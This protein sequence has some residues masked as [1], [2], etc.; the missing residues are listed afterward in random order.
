MKG[1]DVDVAAGRI[2][3]INDTR[4]VTTTDGTLVCILPTVQS[5]TPTMTLPD[6]SKDICYLWTTS[7]YSAG[8]GPLQEGETCC[9]MITALPQEYS[10]DTTLMAVP[11]GADFF[12]GRVKISRTTAPATTWMGR[13]LGVLPVQSQW[14]SIPGSFSALVESEINLS[15]GM[16][17]F[18]SGGNLILRVEQSVGPAPGG[19]GDFPGVSD[20][21][22]YNHDGSLTYV[23]TAGTP[24]Y[25]RHE[26]AY[27]YGGSPG[28]IF[29][30]PDTYKRT[31][32]SP[33]SSNDIHSY[34]SIY[35]VEIEGRF[36]R[37][38]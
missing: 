25:T 34:Q 36:G 3:F 4:T 17:I 21:L 12:I 26:K 35:S 1:L 16:H 28:S 14:M 27:G 19:Y 7:L 24:V 10:S 20:G 31:G 33:C 37:R 22:N 38:S 9:C 30:L 23:T 15:R 29:S 18:I 32:S 11:S 6:V 2:E 13:T 5:F 8:G